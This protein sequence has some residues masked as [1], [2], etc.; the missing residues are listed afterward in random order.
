M[1]CNEEYINFLRIVKYNFKS[2][3]DYFCNF[4]YIE[5]KKK[6]STKYSNELCN[7]MGL[8]WLD[9]MEWNVMSKVMELRMQWNGMYL[10]FHYYVWLHEL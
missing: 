2:N 3:E 10:S 4:H 9:V 5:T 1:Y 7:V 8:A 6:F